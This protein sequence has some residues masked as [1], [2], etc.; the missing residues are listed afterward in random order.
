MAKRLPKLTPEKRAAVLEVVNR[1][2]ADEGISS[3]RCRRAAGELH[4]RTW[5][6]TPR[7]RGRTPGTVRISDAQYLERLQDSY[8]E[9]DWC[10]RLQQPKKLRKAPF[11]DSSPQKN[12]FEK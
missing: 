12:K 7:K 9:T 10:E 5:R 1:A 2:A 8:W 4:D 11:K 3:R 6:K